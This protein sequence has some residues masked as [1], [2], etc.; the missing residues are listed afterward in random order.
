[1][2]SKSLCS[3]KYCGKPRKVG[4]KVCCKHA[5]QAWRLSN[6]ER[7]A[8]MIHKHNAIRRGKI[9][10]LTFEQFLHFCKTSKYLEL[11]GRNADDLSIDRI[12]NERGYEAGNIQPLTVSNNSKK[13][14]WNPISNEQF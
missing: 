11:K 3:I 7:A 13:G 1:M 9:Y 2:K 12:Y 10:T 14:I 5:T 4:C 6:P 8:Y